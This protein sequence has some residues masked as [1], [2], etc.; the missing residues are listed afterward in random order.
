MTCRKLDAH[1]S[2]A[3]T[4]IVLVMTGCAGDLKSPERIYRPADNEMSCEAIDSE[5]ANLLQR[6]PG[7]EDDLASNRAGNLGAWLAGQLLL[8]PTLGMD[9]TGNSEI[10]RTAVIK[11]VIR[12]KDLAAKKNCSFDNMIST[13]PDL[14][15]KN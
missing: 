6:I 1:Q 2:I 8:L 10:Q 7:L 4:A 13:S 15:K 14:L 5:A 3:L 12:L 9:V 11:R